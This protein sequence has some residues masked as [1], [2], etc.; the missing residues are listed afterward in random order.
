M[1]FGLDRKDLDD[2]DG[3]ERRKDEM[4]RREGGGSEK[5]RLRMGRQ[6]VSQKDTITLTEEGVKPSCYFCSNTAISFA[7]ALP[8]TDQSSPPP[9]APCL[10]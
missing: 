7:C 2:L 8:Q 6:R 3:C 1:R 4:E 10:L 5:E 9:N